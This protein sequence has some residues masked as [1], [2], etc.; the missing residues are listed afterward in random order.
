M[1]YNYDD[2]QVIDEME[3]ENWCEYLVRQLIEL[4]V[5]TW[6]GSVDAGSVDAGN[7]D[8]GKEDS[9]LPDEWKSD[10]EMPADDDSPYIPTSQ[11]DNDHLIP[12]S[13][14]DND[15]DDIKVHIYLFSWYL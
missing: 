6:E 8:A 14:E 2:Q 7:E 13:Q 15:D 10:W 9:P 11:E 1:G 3:L 4:S 12:T 5:E